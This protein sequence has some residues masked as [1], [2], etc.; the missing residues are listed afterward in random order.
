MARTGMRGSNRPSIVRVLLW[1]QPIWRSKDIKSK[2]YLIV[3]NTPLPMYH[4]DA[5]LY[6]PDRHH[7]I[8]WY[9]TTSTTAERAE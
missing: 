6:S 5:L 2:W 8:S 7:C 4:I 3:F 1:H 9:D